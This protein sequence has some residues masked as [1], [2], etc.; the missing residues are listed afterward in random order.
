MSGSSDSTSQQHVATGVVFFVLAAALWLTMDNWLV[1]VPF[2][3]L[4]VAMIFWGT[5]HAWRQTPDRDAGDDD[6]VGRPD[7]S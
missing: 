7:R 3:T 6:P 5:R 1:G 4:A 2:A